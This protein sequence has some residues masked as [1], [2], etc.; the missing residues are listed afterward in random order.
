MAA[1]RPRPSRPH[2]IIPVPIPVADG[3]EVAVRPARILPSTPHD[4]QQQED[5]EFRTQQEDLLEQL[6]KHYSP[7]EGFDS[8][9]STFE[10]TVNGAVQATFLDGTRLPQVRDDAIKPKVGI[11]LLMGTDSPQVSQMEELSMT[12]HTPDQKDASW[13]VMTAGAL[14]VNFSVRKDMTVSFS[15]RTPAVIQA[16]RKRIGRDG[17]FVDPNISP[18][19]IAVRRNVD[20]FITIDSMNV[21]IV[22]DLSSDNWDLEALL[23]EVDSSSLMDLISNYQRIISRGGPDLPTAETIQLLDVMIEDARRLCVRSPILFRMSTRRHI[24]C[25]KNTRYGVDDG[26]M[27]KTLTTSSGIKNIIRL[28]AAYYNSLPQLPETQQRLKIP[29]EI[30]PR[31]LQMLVLLLALLNDDDLTELAELLEVTYGISAS[32]EHIELLILKVLP[33][34]SINSK[35]FLNSLVQACE[36]PLIKPSPHLEDQSMVWNTFVGRLLQKGYILPGTVEDLG[37][38][39]QSWVVKWPKNGFKDTQIFK[40]LQYSGNA[41]TINEITPVDLNPDVIS[42]SEIT[43]VLANGRSHIISTADVENIIRMTPGRYSVTEAVREGRSFDLDISDIWLNQ[44][45]FRATADIYSILGLVK[46]IIPSRPKKEIVK[47]MGSFLQTGSFRGDGGRYDDAA[48]PELK[49]CG[50]LTYHV[51][52]LNGQF[53]ALTCKVD[54]RKISPRELIRLLNTDNNKMDA[55]IKAIEMTM[56][57]AFEGRKV[58]EYVHRTVQRLQDVLAGIGR[59]RVDVERRK[60]AMQG[61][62]TSLPSEPISK[63]LFQVGSNETQLAP[64]N[65]YHA[66]HSGAENVLYVD[67]QRTVVEEV[68]WQSDD[69]VAITFQR[70]PARYYATPLKPLQEHEKFEE[71]GVNDHVLLCGHYLVI[72]ERTA[73]NFV[74]SPADRH[75]SADGS[76]RRSWNWEDERDRERLRV[77]HPLRPGSRPGDREGLI[78]VTP[79]QQGPQQRQVHP[80][81][82]R[83]KQL[84]RRPPQMSMEEEIPLDMVLNWLKVTGVEARPGG[85]RYQNR[86]KAVALGRSLIR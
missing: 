24:V 15:D 18:K 13:R 22:S 71:I 64:Y 10:R 79:S 7:Y 49:G 32:R 54:G 81:S 57:A 84:P 85:R 48:M 39:N 8:L 5:S 47:R 78:P 1:P 38:F 53:L 86:Q 36:G 63:V 51:A 82:H 40:N 67:A 65:D 23:V 16:Y 30:R 60:T 58:D 27:F 26:I 17:P 19:A 12:Q 44:P 55:T 42:G 83:Q 80:N 9:I 3:S 31:F 35:I 75:K 45:L 29:S 61:Y 77:P 62:D 66:W 20:R 68:I 76:T 6:T 14:L 73:E 59:M 28:S 2:S 72:V 4:I 46:S 21:S 25:S 69:T 41:R 37:C 11:T 43:V 56:Q 34:S 52:R 74:P 70:V 33:L 50:R